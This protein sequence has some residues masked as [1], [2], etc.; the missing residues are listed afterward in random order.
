MVRT[1]YPVRMSHDSR[2]SVLEACSKLYDQPNPYLSKYL[3]RQSHICQKRVP[4]A[5]PQTSRLSQ[6]SRVAVEL[7]VGRVLQ[8][9]DEAR[10]ERDE[11]ELDHA[12]TL[13]AGA[14]EQHLWLQQA[15]L[16]QH[17]RLPPEFA[18]ELA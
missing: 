3:Q 13:A 15:A 17:E 10:D 1:D 11:G 5:R 6:P 14:K 9:A 7:R 8:T 16:E 4:V 18:D 2:Q 12:Q